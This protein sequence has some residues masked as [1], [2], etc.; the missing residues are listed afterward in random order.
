MDFNVCHCND[1][2]V[3]IMWLIIILAGK[4]LKAILCQDLHAAQPSKSLT[5]S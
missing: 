2:S 1:I 5:D 3:M 4:D